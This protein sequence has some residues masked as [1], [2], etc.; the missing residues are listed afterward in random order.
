MNNQPTCIQDSEERRCVP[1]Q[2]K[3]DHAKS[4]T[5]PSGHYDGTMLSD[6]EADATVRNSLKIIF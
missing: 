2:V 6:Q 4:S 5:R 1:T 3:F